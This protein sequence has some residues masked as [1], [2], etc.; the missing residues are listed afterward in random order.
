MEQDPLPADEQLAQVLARLS[1]A[2]QRVAGGTRAD[3]AAGIELDASKIKDGQTPAAGEK[4][5]WQQ[6]GDKLAA[7][8]SKGSQAILDRVMGRTETQGPKAGG[9]KSPGIIPAAVSSRVQRAAK[10]LKES[11]IGKR[12]AG[13][14]KQVASRIGKSR[15]GRTASKLGGRIAGSAFGRVAGAA[16]GSFAPGVGTVIGGIIGGAVGGAVGKT[17][18]TRGGG[19]GRGGA[20][21]GATGGIVGGLLSGRAGAIG[22]AVAGGVIGGAAGLAA[23]A[24]ENFKKET[25]ESSKR[26]MEI[27]RQFGQFSALM[28]LVNAEADAREAIRERGKGDRLS[29]SAQFASRGDQFRK[30]QNVE[31]DV[32]WQRI[33]SYAMGMKNYLAGIANWPINQLYKVVN[34]AVEGERAKVNPLGE[35]GIQLGERLLKEKEEADKRREEMEKKRRQA[36]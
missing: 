23:K 3:P 10:W 14:G 36:N 13:I 28:G 19:L 33:D 1:D 11:R 35:A 7:A 17:A 29:S 5:D 21:G 12:A 2:I 27:N 16:L 34:G 9:E 24:L 22:G 4:P 18:E 31:S 25:E 15:V 30:D 20:A 8:V 26:L 6:I 32:F